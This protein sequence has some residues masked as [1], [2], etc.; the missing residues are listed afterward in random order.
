[1]KTS[2]IPVDDATLLKWLD[3][4]NPTTR[5]AAA[6]I[7]ELKADLAACKKAKRKGQ[8]NNG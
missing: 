7:Q 2:A 4:T 6:R 8:R 1:M 5:W 3:S